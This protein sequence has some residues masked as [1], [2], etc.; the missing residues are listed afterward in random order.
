M[1]VVSAATHPTRDENEA[2]S[3]MFPALSGDGR[4]NSMDAMPLSP[5]TTPVTR[6]PRRVE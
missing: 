2:V 5:P 4:G 3:T 1:S 6:W